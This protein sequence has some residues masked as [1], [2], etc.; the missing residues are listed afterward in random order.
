MPLHGP[1]RA[2]LCPVL[3]TEGRL[4][5]IWDPEAAVDEVGGYDKQASVAAQFDIIEK[6]LSYGGDHVQL[7]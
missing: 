5:I 6:S 4:D 1:P 3:K 2:I 7:G